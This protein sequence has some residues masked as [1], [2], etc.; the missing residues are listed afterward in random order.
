MERHSRAVLGV[1]RWID[2]ALGAAVVVLVW[3]LYRKVTR[4]WWTYD[5]AYTL[6]VVTSHTFRDFFASPDVWPQ[7]LYTPLEKVTYKLQLAWFGLNTV[8][9]FTLH[10]AVASAAAVSLYAAARCYFRPLAAFVSAALFVAAVPLC[11]QTT[12][13]GSTHYFQA[14]ALAGIAVMLYVGAL[15][16]NRLGLAIASAAFYFVAMF[17][18]ETVVPLV[19]LL[20]VLPERDFRAR[21]RF[22][23]GHAIALVAYL[24]ARRAVI[25]TLL[26]GYGWAVERGEWPSLILSLPRKVVLGMAGQGVIAGAILLALIAIGVAASLRTRRAIVL[27]VVALLLAVG[28]VV[29]VSKEMQRRYVVMPWLCLSIAFVAGTETLRRHP[30]VRASR[31]R[32]TAVSA[33]AV[34]DDRA[35]RPVGAGGTPALRLALLIATLV[36]A[37]LANRQEWRYEFARTKRMSDE[38]RVFFDLQSNGLLRAPI[39]PPA[40]MGELNW[41]KTDYAKH[42]PGAGWF[43]DDI[44]LCRHGAEGQR[45]WQY[46]ARSHEVRELTTPVGCPATR[47]D[48]PLTATFQARDG[49]LFWDFGPYTDGTYRVLIADGIQAFD[50]PRRDGFRPPGVTMLVLRVRYRGASLNNLKPHEVTSLG[51]ARTFQRTSVFQSV[52]VFENVMIGLHRRGRSRLVDTL[53]A[54]PRESE[55]ES[56]L[57]ARAAEILA[58]VGIE[59]R[60]REMAGVLAYGEQRL[61]GVALALATDPSMLLLDEPVS[62]M[63]ATETARFMQLLARL[64]G[65]GMTILLVEHD[66]PMV[67]GVSDRVVVLNYGRIIAEGPPAAIQGNPEVISAYLGQGARKRARN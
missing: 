43:Y 36:M 3:L 4:L 8:R 39:V 40:A 24:A 27:F 34:A 45:F 32:A 67:M 49:A 19:V 61:L 29:P 62:G 35:R 41:L 6:H 13:L 20:V 2:F 66:M 54:L 17:A 21:T 47:A 48:A 56:E 52:S 46:D 53:L 63:N 38:A 5:D 18:K 1:R 16:S 65:L 30:G 60:A 33:V 23:A 14:I 37:V 7:K 26:G 59:R 15:R 64:R 11:S 22:A 50:V 12:E 28:P 31:P 10:L 55:S 44:Y 57:R 9:W 25:G 58:L 51:L 42:D